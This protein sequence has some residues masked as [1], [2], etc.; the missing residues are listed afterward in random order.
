[1][2]TQASS[3]FIE[4]ENLRYGDGFGCILVQ[5]C[6]YLAER[7][8]EAWEN[9]EKANP[10]KV[11]TA[12]EGTLSKSR[13]EEC[14]IPKDADERLMVARRI[15]ADRCLYGVDKNPLAVE[16]AK[17]SLWLITLQKNRPFTFV[18]HALKCGDSLIGVSLEQLRYWNLD[19]NGT[20]ELF[21]DQIRREV[22]KVIELRRDI[23][24]LP[25][26]TRRPKSQGVFISPG[27]C[28]KF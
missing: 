15:I 7:L 5:T 4:V 6:R 9:A 3:R 24:S 20:L 1:M 13:P 14:V 2:E 19:T 8:V 22:D 23:A 16:M 21:A 17:L 26:L 11:V 28:E 27:E 12:P 25:V 18:D 10:G